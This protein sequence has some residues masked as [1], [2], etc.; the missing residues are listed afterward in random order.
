MSHFTNAVEEA[1]LDWVANLGSPTRPAPTHVGLYTT[2]PTDD[3][4]TNGTECSGSGYA[5]QAITFVRTSQTLNPNATITFGPATAADWGTVN[6]FGIFSA[7]TAGTC[8]A[9]AALTTP[10]AIGDGDSAEFATTDLT[11][12]LD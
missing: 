1:V 11:I 8:Y 2:T 5:R 10:R 4:G 6:G 9:Y 12:T 7:I 3:I